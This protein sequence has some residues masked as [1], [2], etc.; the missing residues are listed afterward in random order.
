LKR[1][2]VRRFWQASRRASLFGVHFVRRMAAPTF[3]FVALLTAP[4]LL[5]TLDTVAVETPA[6]R[7][8][9]L[10]VI[11]L[12]VGFAHTVILLAKISSPL[13]VE[14]YEKPG[15]CGMVHLNY[16]R[17]LRSDPADVGL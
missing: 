11:P 10:I 7:A 13:V 16:G 9:S 14:A 4:V 15:V 1:L 2:A 17:W 12:I 8:T 6:N 3:S 5:T